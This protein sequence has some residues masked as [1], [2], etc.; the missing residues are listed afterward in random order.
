MRPLLLALPFAL[1]PLCAAQAHDEHEHGSLG[2]HEHGTAQLNVALDGQTLEIELDSPAMNIVGFE[3]AA[4]T[5]EQKAQAAAAQQRLDKPETLFALPAAAKCIAAQSE[6]NSPVF[7]DAAPS[8]AHE[9]HEHADVDGHYQFQCDNPSALA[10]IDFAPFFKAFPGT[11][12]IAVQAITGSGQ[13]GLEATP[14]NSVLK[15]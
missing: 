11:H 7:A 13:K 3:H 5:A 2:A 15:F 9:G 12:K 14:A 6:V 1:L 8:K 4:T 10:S